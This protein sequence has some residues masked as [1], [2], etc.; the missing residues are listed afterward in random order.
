MTA[1]WSADRR[2]RTTATGWASREICLGT[3]AEDTASLPPEL[4]D[5]L[6][7]S[8]SLYRRIARL[9][10][11]LFGEARH[12]PRRARQ[13]TRWRKLS[14]LSSAL[15]RRKANEW[16]S[17]PFRMCERPEPSEGQGL[18]QT[19]QT[20]NAADRGGVFISGRAKTLGLHE[21]GELLVEARQAAATI[22][23]LLLTAGPGR[24]GSRGRCPG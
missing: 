24:D 4:R 2:D 23:Q 6:V 3:C 12:G 16:F 19:P 21:A 9:D 13:W 22:H 17:E 15:V 5:L 18:D 7:R 1:T 11:I 20:K 14:A 10:D 8:D